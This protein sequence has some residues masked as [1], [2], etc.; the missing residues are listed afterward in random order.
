M[1][2]KL[3]KLALAALLPILMHTAAATAQTAD[4][5]FQPEEAEFLNSCASCHGADG[6]GAGFLTRLFRGVDPGD[7]TQ[8]AA[9]NDGVFPYDRVYQV[10]DGRDDIAA[11]GDRKMPVW[12]DRY[13]SSSMSQFGPD[14]V[15][16]F[17]VR[18]RILELTNFIQSIQVR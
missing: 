8:L 1:T 3:K 14:E 2:Q 5:G 17:R 7:L 15:N 12:G 11:H 16:Q 6:K 13:M 4:E 18:S 10:I 9:N